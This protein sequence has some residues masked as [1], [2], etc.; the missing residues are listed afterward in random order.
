VSTFTHRGRAVGAG[1]ALGL[2]VSGLSLMPGVTPAPTAAA[3]TGGGS[4]VY[5]K[6]YNVWITNGD[7][8]QQA[9]VTSG[10]TAADPWQSPTQSDNGVVVAHHGGL[11]YRMNQRG[12]VLNTIDPPALP[13][14]FGNKLEG[15]DLADTAI[16]PDGTKI[17][18]TYFK[19][20]Y[21]ENRWVTAFTDATKLTNFETWGLSFYAKPS[22]VTG[23]RVVL[24]HWYRNK[25]HLY[26]LGQR[27]IP[28]FEE[29]SY[30]AD[31]K[32]LSD[33]EVSRDG[34]WTVA[35]RGDVG[36]QN[37]VVLRNNGDVK[38][39]ASPAAPSFSC[40][41]GAPGVDTAVR[42]P[43]LAPDASVVAWAE[44]GGIYRSSD[45]NCDGNT[46]VD[47]LVAAG[48][49]D[50]SWS[51]AVIGQTPVAPKTQLEVKKQPQVAGKAAVGKVLSVKTGV[52]V[53]KPKSFSFRWMR[54]GK[55]IA[56]ATKARYKLTKKDRGHKVSVKVT[57]KR[58][59]YRATVTKSKP[60]RVKR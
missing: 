12:E 6:D 8:G 10:G 53:P 22:W 1:L 38:T 23:S 19:F 34:Q 44:P 29:G 36:D 56:K 47:I 51:A 11:I 35:T 24:N 7:G 52:W 54:D 58:S 33:L 48:G 27:D 39:T 26:D 30:T 57:A 2:A 14:S 49:S 46:R 37:V 45:M 41:I 9:Q 43:T 59:G 28:W 42:E 15:R 4:I 18:Y 32:E 55:P 5:V 21:G 40:L 13:D 16:S 20:S 31:R 17:A 60:V 3:A 25:T 50:P